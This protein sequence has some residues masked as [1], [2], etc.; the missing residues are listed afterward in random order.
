[1]MV[2]A[3]KYFG[4]ECIDKIRQVLLTLAGE[5]AGNLSIAQLFLTSPAP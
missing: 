5:A 2:C 4:M 1:M 3:V